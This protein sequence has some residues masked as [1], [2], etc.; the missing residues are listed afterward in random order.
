VTEPGGRFLEVGGERI[1]LVERGSGPPVLLIHGFPSNATAFASLMPLLEDR[2]ALTAVDMVGFGLSTRAI[3]RPLDGD[4]YADRMV[5]LLDA[6]ELQRPHV[7]GL[8]WGGSVAQRLAARHP[9]RV[10]RLVLLAAVSAARVLRLSDANLLGLALAMRFPVIGR[11]VVRRFVT[12]TSGD[13]DLASEAL[14]RGYVEPLGIP[15]TLAALRRFVRDTAATPPIDLGR[16]RA[17]AL[18]VVPLADRIVSPEAGAE[19]A[20]AIPSA[21]YVALPGIGHAV[22]F[23]A[24]QRVAELIRGFLG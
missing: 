11:A 5:D 10:D 6:L 18:V 12:H 22:Q 1:H 19:I 4:S 24:R 13:A 17:P 20:A 9:A 21:Q 15:G 7:V 16:I 23:E 8:S 2:F 3:R 14:V